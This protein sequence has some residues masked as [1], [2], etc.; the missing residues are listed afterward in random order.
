LHCRF[1]TIPTLY[2]PLPCL[3]CPFLMLPSRDDDLSHGR[4]GM[5]RRP[6]A[7]GV[8]AVFARPAGGLDHAVQ[9]D[10]FNDPDLSHS[11][12]RQTSKGSGSRQ[13]HAGFADRGWPTWLILLRLMKSEKRTSGN[14]SYRPLHVQPKRPQAPGLLQWGRGPRL[15]RF[16]PPRAP[17]Y[18][19][20]TAYSLN[21]N[22]S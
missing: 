21:G 1:W 6:S 4:I 17:A 13:L 16:F 8:V 19:S 3:A 18:G 7:I 2:S 15:V 10:M 14:P 9:G 20:F 11:S 12:L 22:G 5:R